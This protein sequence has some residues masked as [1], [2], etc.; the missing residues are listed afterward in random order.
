MR[1]KLLIS[2]AMTS[3][4]VAQPAY[5]SNKT[6]DDA[7]TIV[8]GTLTATAL[9]LPLIR[10]DT[11]GLQQAAFSLA[12]GT[13]TAY[14]LK[15]VIESRRPDGNGNDSFPSAHTS[16]SFSAAATLQQ[17]Y[18]W[19]IGAPAF[20]AATFVGI[21]R[22]KANRHRWYD[23]VAG[24]AIGSGAGILLTTPYQQKVAVIP[25]GDTKGGGISVAM[26]F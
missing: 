6:W 17:R 2:A 8:A 16:M 10:E 24:A 1:G 21:A 11:K 3:L 9:G 18:G 26:R 5:A 7:S 22:V 20:V 23:V 25:Y 14:G 15:S 4:A 13:G 19:G 12:V